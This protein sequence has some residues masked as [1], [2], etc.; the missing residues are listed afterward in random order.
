MGMVR[1][2]IMCNYLSLAVLQIVK[3]SEAYDHIYN[4]SVNEGFITGCS[5][6]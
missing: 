1:V 5:A 4:G 6:G 2:W 3:Q